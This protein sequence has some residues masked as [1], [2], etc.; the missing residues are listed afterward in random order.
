[1]WIKLLHR[2]PRRLLLVFVW[3]EPREDLK[4]ENI[5]RHQPPP[6]KSGKA[7]VGLCLPGSQHYDL[8]WTFKQVRSLPE[9]LQ[10]ECLLRDFLMGLAVLPI[11]VLLSSMCTMGHSGVHKLVPLHCSGKP[12]FRTTC[13]FEKAGRSFQTIPSVPQ[14]SLENCIF[15][16]GSSQCPD[17][18]VKSIRVCVS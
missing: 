16:L 1:M 11:A 6:D 15:L 18:S 4:H 14:T 13:S 12:G 8:I 17:S 7:T 10:C 9:V 5:F 2:R 3:P